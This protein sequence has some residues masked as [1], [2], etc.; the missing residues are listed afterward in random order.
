MQNEAKK[1]LKRRRDSTHAALQECLRLTKELTYTIAEYT[2]EVQL[3]ELVY[4]RTDVFALCFSYADPQSLKS[5]EDNWYPEI[6]KVRRSEGPYVSSPVPTRLRTL[7]CT[8]P[9]IGLHQACPNV[10]IVLIGLRSDH[11]DPKGIRELSW[12]AETQQ[13]AKAIEAKVFFSLSAVT[14][15]QW[16]VAEQFR[17]VYR[18]VHAAGSQVQST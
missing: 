6:S 13:T 15:E 1:M 8:L 4:P 2:V 10:P 16:D 7:W 9:C 18:F 11:G 5:L 14:S 17:Q 12:T 3:R